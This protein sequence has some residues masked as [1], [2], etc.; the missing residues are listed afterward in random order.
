L[1]S[2][3]IDMALR[4]A[5]RD[6]RDVESDIDEGV[7][8]T[9]QNEVH[10]RILPV[11]AKIPYLG[12]MGVGN[13][14]T[15]YRP[16]GRKL[17]RLPMFLAG[18]IQWAQHWISRVYNFF[19]TYAEEIWKGIAVYSLIWFDFFSMVTVLAVFYGEHRIIFPGYCLYAIGSGIFYL[20]SSRKAKGHE[21]QRFL[22]RR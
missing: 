13:D 17:I 10:S 9:P 4:F 14:G 5:R 12:I 7:P 16:D 2:F 20:I 21:S 22:N 18:K 8:A 19:I 3:Y 15:L 11:I 6:I 1:L